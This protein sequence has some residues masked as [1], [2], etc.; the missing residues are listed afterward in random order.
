M[1]SQTLVVLNVDIQAQMALIKGVHEK[2]VIRA[3][4]LQPND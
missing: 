3:K 4:R 1:D 2:L